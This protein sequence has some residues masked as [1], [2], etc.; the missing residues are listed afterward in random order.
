MRDVDREMTP[1]DEQDRRAR[2]ETLGRE[3]YGDEFD[4]F[5]R[6]PR[7]SLDWETPAAMIERGDVEPVIDILTN[8]LHGNFG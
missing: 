7:R 1:A 5:L 2:I 6:T 4:T 3:V 8:A